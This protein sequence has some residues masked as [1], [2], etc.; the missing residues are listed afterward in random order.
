MIAKIGIDLGTAGTSIFL[1]GR[2]IVLTEPTVVAVDE[3]TN[4]IL[5]VG[6]EAKEMIGKTPGDNKNI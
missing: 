3:L 2:G 6:Q 4:K 1:P 5:A